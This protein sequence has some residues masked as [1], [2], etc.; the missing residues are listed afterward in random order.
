MRHHG[1]ASERR[2]L[3]KILAADQRVPEIFGLRTNEMI[4][5]AGD[6]RHLPRGSRGVPE[7]KSALFGAPL[8]RRRLRILHHLY[9]FA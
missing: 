3:I 2:Q 6:A 1:G 5:V 8:I 4:A 9:D 7:M